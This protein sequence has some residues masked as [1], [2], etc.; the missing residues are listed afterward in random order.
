M[1]IITFKCSNYVHLY[2]NKCGVAPLYP[3]KKHSSI[4]DAKKYIEEVQGIYN[5]KIIKNK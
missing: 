2:Y 1:K 5:S 3:Y 4:K